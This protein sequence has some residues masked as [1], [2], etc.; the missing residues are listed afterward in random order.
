MVGLAQLPTRSVLAGSNS[1]G[2]IARGYVYAILRELHQSFRPVK[3]G[4]HVHGLNLVVVG[5]QHEVGALAA[6]ATVCTE[7]H[8][9]PLKERR[10]SRSRVMHAVL[11]KGR[12]WQGKRA[13]G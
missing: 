11:K 8:L 13:V 2:D 9:G 1:S 10:A 7:A 6:H 3:L 5:R 12:K 4:V